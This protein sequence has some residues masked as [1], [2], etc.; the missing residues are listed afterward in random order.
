MFISIARCLSPFK[1]H[2]RKPRARRFDS[3]YLYNIC[4]YSYIHSI[5][6]HQSE[7][8]QQCEQQKRAS[9][10]CIYV[11]MCRRRS[12]LVEAAITKSTSVQFEYS[13]R[14]N[15][16]YVSIFASRNGDIHVWETCIQPTAWL[17]LCGLADAVDCNGSL[18]CSQRAQFVLSLVPCSPLLRVFTL[19]W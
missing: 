9:N 18:A 14:S 8:K 17:I 2:V 19:T 5:Y 3:P 11:S 16:E 15:T 7:K 4:T 1:V 12:S 6:S 13:I 10:I